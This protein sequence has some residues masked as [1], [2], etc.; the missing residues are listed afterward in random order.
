MSLRSGRIRYTNA[1]PLYAAFDEG[2]LPYPGE[3]H[4]GVPSRLNAMLLDGELDLGPMS[5]YAWA[6]RSD[7]LVLLPG[8]CIGARDEVLSVLLASPVPP[9]LLEGATVAV[10]PDSESGRNLLRVLLERRYGVL[11]RYEVDA[12]ALAAA[13]AGRPALL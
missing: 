12:G 13:R 3:L 8:P 6:R 9:A 4:A 10:T 1:L 11:P 7:D 2:A 5:A